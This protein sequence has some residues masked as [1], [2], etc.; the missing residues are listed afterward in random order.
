MEKGKI[1]IMKLLW[2]KNGHREQYELYCV[3]SLTLI[4]TALVP[5]LSS[6][7]EWTALNGDWPKLIKVSFSAALQRWMESPR[8]RLCN[9]GQDFLSFHYLH[10]PEAVQSPGSTMHL[11]TKCHFLEGRLTESCSA[12]QM[13]VPGLRAADGRPS[14]KLPRQSQC[15]P[16]GI[17]RAIWN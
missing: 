1:H 10:L 6:S 3:V 8:V 14:R 2:L 11:L 4:T 15:W 13:H 5:S 9:R 16:F 7:P 17:Q 12:A